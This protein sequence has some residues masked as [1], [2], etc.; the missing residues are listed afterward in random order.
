MAHPLEHARSSVRKFGGR[1]ED[2]LHVHNWLDGSKLL[3]AD[4]RHR[5]LR[6][7]AEGI[8][9]CETLFGV[10]VRNSAGRDVPVRLIAEQHVREDLGWIPT[11]Q[12]WLRNLK[13][14]PWMTRG[15]TRLSRVNAAE[16]DDDGAGNGSDG[17]GAA[18][19]GSQDAEG[20]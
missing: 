6:H 8:F 16:R 19:G 20:L 3:V 12:D 11:A 1:V 9:M 4:W 13:H 10:S 18:V 17:Q 14:E 5:A 2:Y 7:H 15:V